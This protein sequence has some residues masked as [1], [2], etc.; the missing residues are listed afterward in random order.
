MAASDSIPASLVVLTV[1]DHPLI[2]SALRE[3]LALMRERV[4]LLE[5]G[6]PVAG[7]EVLERRHGV[8][9]VFLDAHFAHHDGLAFIERFRAAAPAAP[10]IMYTMREDPASVREALER[11]AAGIVPKTYPVRELQQAIERVM[12]GGI[13]VPPHL[14]PEMAAE[15]TP[16]LAASAM[17]AQQRRILELV[18]EGMPNKAIARQLGLSP[19]TIKNQ[20]TAVFTKLGVSNRTQAAIAARALLKDKPPGH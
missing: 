5:A 18:A 10:L 2:R 9:L 11:G 4:E 12:A 20:L 17:S 13:Y 14:A 8:D 7:L 6:D 3:V 19:S 1:D 16:G 15:P